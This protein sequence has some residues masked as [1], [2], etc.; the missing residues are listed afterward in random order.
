ME[1]E[2]TTEITTEVP[3]EQSVDTPSD[4][5]PTVGADVP[6]SDGSQKPEG[7]Q[8][9]GGENGQSQL[10]DTTP[11][12]EPEYFFGDVSVS[13]DIPED[14]STA[15]SEKGLDAKAIAAELYSKEGKFDLSEE[16]KGK[17]YEAFGKF[18]V[19]AYLSGLKATNENFFASQEREAAQRQ[20]A[21]TER[22]GL[23]A[24]TVGGDE[25]WSRLEQFALETLSDEELEQFNE[26]MRS[27][28]MYFQQLAVKDLEARRAAAQGDP[29]VTLIQA[30]AARVSNENGPLTS[31]E[32]MKAIAELSTKF[33][34]D[35]AGAA[36]AE[37]AL[38]ERRRA[39]MARGI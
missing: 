20:A 21:D 27:G 15:L 33:K 22:Y 28:N 1:P 26:S 35:R 4:S 16:T 7:E 24:A 29:S 8:G 3:N 14:V 34:G 25:G 10:D 17:L 2:I 9:D 36:A 38:D 12:E 18:A 39:G 31:A 11:V 23:V 30:D 13:I 32:Y 6:D 19:D 37:K 5:V